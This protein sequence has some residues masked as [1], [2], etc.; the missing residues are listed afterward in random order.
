AQ[1]RARDVAPLA[2]PHQIVKR[3]Q[4]LLDWR[5]RVRPV[6][7]VEIEVVGAQPAKAR[8][9]RLRDV[10]PRR[11]L[12]LAGVVHRHAELAGED[13]L[14]ALRAED[15]AERLL[16]SAAIAVCVGGVDQGAA[17][18]DRLVHHP[19]RRLEV[20]AAAEIVGAEPDG[21]DL[22]GGASESAFLHRRHCGRARPR[23]LRASSGVAISRPSPRA[24]PTM[25]ST[26]TAL[27]LAS[28]PGAR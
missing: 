22:E 16:R 26:S 6:Q 14:S 23:I 15:A 24:M 20:D 10:A 5:L 2:L 17:E 19:A 27:F 3:A 12:E 13:D 21:R 25:R 4:R 18:I 1:L 8:L 7:L 28:S 9:D 11:S